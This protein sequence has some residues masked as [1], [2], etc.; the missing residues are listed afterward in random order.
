MNY[1]FIIIINQLLP[2]ILYLIIT[3]ILIKTIIFIQ[4]DYY[5]R[6]TTFNK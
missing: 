6:F 5:F 1:Y 4:F 2:S 3:I